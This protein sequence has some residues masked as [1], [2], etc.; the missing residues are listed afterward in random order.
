MSQRV[1]LPPLTVIPAHLQT[2]LDYQQQAPQHLTEEVWS[3]LNGG[4]MHE[5]SVQQNMLQFQD[6][7]NLHR[8]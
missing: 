7:R 1:P 8:E 5:I 2:V 6:M 4:A 3:Y